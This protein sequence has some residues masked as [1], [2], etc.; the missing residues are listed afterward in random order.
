LRISLSGHDVETAHELGWSELTN[1][2]LL[3]AAENAGFEIFVTADR[4]LKYQQNLDGRNIVILVLSTTSWPRIQNSVSK[5]VS[6]IDDS[7][8]GDFIEIEIP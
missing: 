6:A 5:V 8:S 1:G 3:C 4:N 7:T 2:D